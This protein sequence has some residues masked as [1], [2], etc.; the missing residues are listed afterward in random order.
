MYAEI[1]SIRL[2]GTHLKLCAIQN[3]VN[4]GYKRTGNER[5][6]T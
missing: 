2:H 3:T 4:P 5:N 1:I 6:R